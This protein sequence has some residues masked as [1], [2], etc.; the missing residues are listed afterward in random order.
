MSFAQDA[1]QVFKQR[2]KFTSRSRIGASEA[3]QAF[4]ER[5]GNEQVLVVVPDSCCN[6]P[7]T[8]FSVPSGPHVLWQ[9]WGKNMGVLSPGLK[10]CWGPWKGISHVVTKAA[11]TYDA[12]SY[13][14]PTAD[15]VM[16]DVDVSMTFSISGYEQAASDF[17]YKIG[18]VNFTD[19][20]AAKTEEA[21]RALVYGVTH[22]K[23]N[24]L[25]EEFATH[26]LD[27]LKSKVAQFGVRMMNVKVTNVMLPKE[28]QVRLEKT[29]TFQTKIEEASKK[30]ENTVLLLQNDC[31][32][33]I[34]AIRKDNLRRL[35]DLQAECE[36]YEI[37]MQELEDVEKG[38]ARVLIT[39]R[40]AEA[41]SRLAKAN[42][43]LEI[44]KAQGERDA[45]ELVRSTRIRC[46]AMR[47]KTDE[48]CQTMILKSESKLAA[49]K[50]EAQ[51][52]I[53]KAEAEDKAVD[54]LKAKREYEVEWKRLATMEK[55]AREGR[56]VLTG[57]N[58]DRILD[59]VIST[60]IKSSRKQ[61]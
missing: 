27:N 59:E 50:N 9:S 35:Q 17:V 58:A 49:A 11:I 10:M 12:P 55:I 43:D 42:G 20:M 31:H 14:V 29:T 33:Q 6:C 57:E 15:N 60:G 51:G 47:I 48:E 13:K 22:N 46:D 5:S 28:L 23:V 8:C 41:E 36:R 2:T 54:N 4:N 21:V 40:R 53:L 26:M 18:P 37:E 25:R 7:L 1:S 16:V 24:D 61:K 56:K 44:S 32:K 19:Y 52:M 38:K 34:E 30:Q 39:E 45:E 3:D